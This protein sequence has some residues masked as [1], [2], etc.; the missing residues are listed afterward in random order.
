MNDELCSARELQG[1][2][3]ADRMYKHSRSVEHTVTPSTMLM[4]IGLPDV[5][6]KVHMYASWVPQVS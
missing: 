5:R 4:Q 2:T 3:V 1:G 6:V